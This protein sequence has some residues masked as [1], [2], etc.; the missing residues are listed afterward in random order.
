MISYCVLRRGKVSAVTDA[1]IAGRST[2]QDAFDGI[3]IQ[4]DEAVVE[5]LIAA[6]LAL[7]KGDNDQSRSEIDG[8]LA[9]RIHA[10]LRLPRQW[11]A[12]EDLWTWLAAVPFRRF[13]EKRWP[14][15]ETQNSWRYTDKNLLRNGVSR[16]W[17]A[18]ELLRDGP[19]YSLVSEP[20]KKV[21][22]FQ[23]VS[24]LRYSWHKECARAF[25]R[26]I[27]DRRIGSEGAKDLSKRVNVYLR[28][29][30]LELSDQL[31]PNATNSIDNEWL[32]HRPKLAELTCPV[33]ELVGPR[34][35]YSRHDVEETLY[36]WIG[37]LAEMCKADPH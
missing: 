1:L 14:I 9:P 23:F 12:R 7:H 30:G 32:S 36:G 18:A 35:G 16:L 20:V 8:Y 26:V 37:S 34:D 25:A 15:G 6:A 31:S 13:M 33:G 24:E 5:K 29:R 11:A 17:W 22:S 10:V 4:F 27:E 21:Y 28:S 3:G 2:P 19:D